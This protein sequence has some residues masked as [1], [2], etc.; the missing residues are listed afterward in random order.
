MTTAGEYMAVLADV[1]AR[2]ELHPR[3]YAITWRQREVIIS[4]YNNHGRFV[5]DGKWCVAIWPSG[6]PGHPQDTTNVFYLG[7][8][9]AWRYKAG[10][11]FDSPE[12]AV[13]ALRQATVEG[14]S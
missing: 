4:R 6:G 8:D 7:S 10:D 1:A 13:Q 2:W 11:L 12:V 5:A 14:L 3:E 9:G